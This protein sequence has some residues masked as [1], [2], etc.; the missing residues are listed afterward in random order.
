MGGLMSYR[1]G[2]RYEG[3]TSTDR[4]ESRSALRYASGECQPGQ[5]DMRPDG[6]GGGVCACG[7]RVDREEL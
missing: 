6:R 4:E 3:V 2:D 7:E 5:H 1:Y